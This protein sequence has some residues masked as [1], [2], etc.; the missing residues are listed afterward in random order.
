MP[1]G[2]FYQRAFGARINKRNSAVCDINVAGATIGING[3]GEGEKT[4]TGMSFQVADVLEG[5]R[6]PGRS[7]RRAERSLT[8]RDP[9][10]I[11]HPTSLCAWISRAIR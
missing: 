6:E 1:I 8:N 11:N 2:S 7:W 3:G 5:A 9:K 4:P 10:A